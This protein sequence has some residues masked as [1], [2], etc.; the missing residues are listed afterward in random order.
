MSKVFKF[1]EPGKSK[2]NVSQFARKDL[3]DT[4]RSLFK[5]MFLVPYIYNTTNVRFDEIRISTESIQDA[6]GLKK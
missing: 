3:K 5:G 1:T 2:I 6:V 4:K